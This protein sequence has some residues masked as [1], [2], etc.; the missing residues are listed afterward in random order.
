MYCDTLQVAQIKKFHASKPR[1]FSLNDSG[2]RDE[3]KPRA[4]LLVGESD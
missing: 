2:E 4:L 1:C 3:K